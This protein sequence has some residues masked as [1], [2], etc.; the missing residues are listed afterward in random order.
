ML[1]HPFVFTLS[2]FFVLGGTSC[3][4]F[5]KHNFTVCNSYLD[6]HI[7]LVLIFILLI[8]CFSYYHILLLYYLCIILFGTS[9]LQLL[10]HYCH[11][12]Y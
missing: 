12:R 1:L 10:I 8:S 3:D 6:I 5:A 7:G 9:E 11:A 2:D 4:F